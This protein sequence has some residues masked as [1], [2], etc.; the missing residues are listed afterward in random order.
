VDDPGTYPWPVRSLTVKSDGDAFRK[1][2]KECRDVANGTKDPKAKR[3]LRD[4]ATELDHEAE[5]WTRRNVTQLVLERR[6]GH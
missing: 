3:Q 5:K 4:L 2:A 1:R 6:C